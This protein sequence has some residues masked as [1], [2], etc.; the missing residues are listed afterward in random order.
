MLKPNI[1]VLL[2][3]SENHLERHGTLSRY[4]GI[5]ARI[6]SQQNAEDLAI[7]NADDE[8]VSS[9]ESNLHSKVLNFGTGESCNARIEYS[10]TDNVDRIVFDDSSLDLS[11]CKLYGLH[12]RSNVAVA[13]LVARELG[14]SDADIINAVNSFSTLE[15]RL[16]L[17]PN[18]LDRV[19]INDS[20]STTVAAC[21][22]AVLATV[23]RYREGKLT[24]MIGGLAKAGS[25]KPVIQEFLHFKERL[26]A[27]ICFGE[28]GR[29]LSVLCQDID[30]PFLVEAKVETALDQAIESSTSGDIILF[31]PG[32]ASFDEFRDFEE[33]GNMF[34]SYVG[35]I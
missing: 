9:L 19:I 35:S 17:V 27:V 20:K 7:L 25:W 16:E 22:A 15:H 30:M 14:T 5:K 28:D 8:M 21:R 13:A 10:P 3:L 33:R 34:K 11:S 2:N 31:S 29:M 18:N 26:N 6:F 1:G 32:C 12:N 24:I 4:L 23:E